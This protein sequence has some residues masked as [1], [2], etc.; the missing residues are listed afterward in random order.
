MSDA[1]ETP[2]SVWIGDE[3]DDMVACKVV[4]KSLP[5]KKFDF[6]C[7]ADRRDSR[8]LIESRLAT[9]RAIL[10]GCPNVRVLSELDPKSTGGT[11]YLT[12]P[13]PEGMT[14]QQVVDIVRP[15]S[16][17]CYTGQFNSR[18]WLIQLEELAVR[19]FIPVVEY[20]TLKAM[21]AVQFEALASMF[22]TAG[23]P[24]S[25]LSPAIS[26]L[27]RKHLEIFNGMHVTPDRFF[28]S[29]PRE[30]EG[31]IAKAQEALRKIQDE[32]KATGRSTIS[33]L[34]ERKH[35]EDGVRILKCA[36]KK[37]PMV[38][39][40]VPPADVLLALPHILPQYSVLDQ[41][42]ISNWR[43]FKFTLRDAETLRKAFRAHF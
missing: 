27:A 13:L 14:L 39:L 2:T 11:L 28:S 8:E 23:G 16:V 9:A 10:S 35:T 4:A 31:E 15:D 12:S 25:C 17:E 42:G 30:F 41:T 36:G 38:D 43:V 19:T 5:Q 7:R 40:A 3:V 24:Q 21:D 22:S 33:L 20:S 37:A 18:S 1:K 26:E 32:A 34:A 6:V 29:C